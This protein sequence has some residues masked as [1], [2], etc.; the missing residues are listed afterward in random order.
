MKVIR[1]FCFF[2]LVL[3]SV[4]ICKAQVCYL[5]AVKLEIKDSKDKVINNAKI[6]VFQVLESKTDSFDLSNNFE[7]DNFYFIHL[8]LETRGTFL[9]KIKADGFAEKEVKVHFDRGHLQTVKINLRKLGTNETEKLQRTSSLG[10]GVYD[11]TGALIPNARIEIKD[12]FGKTY[13]TVSTENGYYSADLTYVGYFW[14]EKNKNWESESSKPA[15]YSLKVSKQGFKDFEIK[16][17]VFTKAFDGMNLD[18]VLES[19]NPEPCGYGGADCLP[20]LPE[21]VDAENAEVSNKILEK[22][23]EKKPKAKLIKRKNNK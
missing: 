23:V 19:E 10:G 9:L 12:E 13:E 17:F 1:F 21:K 5:S 3:I 11:F 14:N 15:K 7:K 8:G 4:Q 2:A 16:N 6:E 22:P 18:V 20:N